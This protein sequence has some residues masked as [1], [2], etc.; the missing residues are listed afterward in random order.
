M[1]ASQQ[2]R[3]RGLPM[4]VFVDM[5]GVVSDFDGHFMDVYGK[6]MDSMTNKEKGRFWDAECVA[7]RFFANSPAIEEGCNLVTNLGA[8]G[9]SVVFLTSTGGQLQHIDIAKQK[10]DF[11][12][13]AGFWMYPVVFAT[14]TESKAKFASP[15]SVLVDDRQKVVDAFRGNGGTAHLFKRELWQDIFEEIAGFRVVGD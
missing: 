15:D 11:L 8:S 9:F 12:N 7:L 14:G 3:N 5:D 2:I 6:P 10:L 1:A 13:R 4:L